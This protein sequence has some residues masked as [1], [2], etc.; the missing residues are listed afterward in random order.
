MDAMARRKPSLHPFH[1]AGI[2]QFEVLVPN[3]LAS[4]EQAVS[5]LLR[6][7]MHIALHLFEPLHAIA[8]RALQLE[9]F[10][11]TFLLVELQG[12]LNVTVV[13]G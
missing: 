7:Q 4:G 10:D 12:L 9:G 1:V 13:M 2:A 3:A 6:I 8:G 11:L 5:K